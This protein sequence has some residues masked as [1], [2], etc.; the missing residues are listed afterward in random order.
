[1]YE[2]ERPSVDYVRAGDVI[3]VNV[4]WTRANDWFVFNVQPI[5]AAFRTALSRTFNVLAMSPAEHWQPGGT[6]AIDL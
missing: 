4:V 1:M 2:R 3:R 5:Y 6:I